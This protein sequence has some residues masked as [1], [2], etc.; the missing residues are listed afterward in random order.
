[1]KWLVNP[2][3][4]L[5]IKPRLDPDLLRWL[6]RFLSASREKP[7][8]RAIP[9]LASLLLSSLKLF[10]ELAAEFQFGFE[11]R[12]GLFLFNTPEGLAGAVQH[13]HMLRTLGI[14]SQVLDMQGVC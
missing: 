7:Y 5:Y 1:F 13:A 10:D 9:V 12:G 4:P 6:W 8:R 3:S 11:R 2:E 14:E